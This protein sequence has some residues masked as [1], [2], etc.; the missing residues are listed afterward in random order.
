VKGPFYYRPD[1]NRAYWCH[2]KPE[3][4]VRRGPRHYVMVGSKPDGTRVET[5][6]TAGSVHMEGFF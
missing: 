3:K 5:R 6:L 4:L 1:P 2:A